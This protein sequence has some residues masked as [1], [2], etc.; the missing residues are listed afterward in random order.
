MKDINYLIKV[1][2]RL[3]IANNKDFISDELTK[4]LKQLIINHNKDLINDYGVNNFK[5]KLAKD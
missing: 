1:L 5:S 3:T 4:K 2:Q